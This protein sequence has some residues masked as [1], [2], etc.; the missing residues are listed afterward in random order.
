[1]KKLSI[2][3]IGVAVVLA[4]YRIL[5]YMDSDKKEAS[6][7]EFRTIYSGEVTTLNYLTTATANEFSLAV[8]FVDSLV[9][10][11]R[12]GNIKPSLATEWSV[13]EDGLIWTFKLRQGVKWVTYE[14]E[15]Y[16]LVKAEDFVDGLKYVLTSENKSKTANIVY[17]MIKN[18]KEYY[19]KE[20][21]DFN[22][23]GVKALD[24][25][26]LQYTLIKPIP[27]FL[28]TLTYSCFFP[29]KGQFLEKAGDKFGIDNRY[30]LYNGPYV[31]TSYEPHH[32]RLLEKNKY[33]WDKE[34][35]HIDRITMTYNK[36]ASVLAPEMFLR[37]EIDHVFIGP[38]IIHEWMEDEEKKNLIRPN[39]TNFFSYFYCFNFNPK[40]SEEYEPHNW[41]IA[42]NNKSFRK[43]LFHALDRKSAML[44]EEP[45][46]PEKRLLNT[47]TPRGFL[48]LGKVDYTELG[49]L[50]KF[51][52]RDSFD[53]ELALIY[54]EKA[55]E[56]LRDKV[57]FPVKV[58]MPYNTGSR[59]WA[60]RTQVIKQ[61]LERILGKDYIEV[62][63]EPKPPTGFLEK[64][65]NSGK[66]GL[67]ELNWGADFADPETYTHPFRRDSTFSWIHMAK[68]YEVEGG[69]TIYEN[70]VKEAR[71]EAMNINKRYILF[72]EAEA[73]LIEEALIIPYSVGGGGYAASR[74]NPFHI[75][76]SPFG[77]MSG[78][79]KGLRPLEAPMNTEEY[80]REFKKW[81]QE[82]KG[83]VKGEGQ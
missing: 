59:Q 40:F 37:G 61:Q 13:S 45:Y 67:M 54:K 52:H 2:F 22:Q 74:I 39:R 58:L 3:F 7:G 6:S 62:I 83:M 68:G 25:Y 49:P 77:A 18:A 70:M 20:I 12:F 75:S 38:D 24:E 30:I 5:G 9:E 19:N 79:F 11:D 33:Y 31:M 36:E 55:K 46:E 28:S 76:Y 56:E 50:A 15:V 29:V 65:R 72:A 4:G 42:V 78:S 73:F 34:K 53:E 23:V 51:T 41:K 14:G 57:S 8:N 81:E 66:Y 27:Y 1:M 10:Y 82:K 35:V 48:S 21:A 69:Y 63:I 80:Y 32:R 16:D 43:S 44:T 47:I 60:N 26:T 17:G 64:V 71:E